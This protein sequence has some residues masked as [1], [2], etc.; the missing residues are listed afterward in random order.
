MRLAPAF[1]FLLTSARVLAAD[2]ALV[3]G[4][5]LPAPDAPPVTDAVI[6][7]RD[8]RIAAI[9]PRASVVVPPAAEVLDCTGKFLTAGFWNVHVHLIGPELAGAGQAPAAQLEAALTEM[10]TRWGFTTAFDLASGLD[11]TLALRERIAR[12][13]VAGP[14]ILT[15]GEPLWPEMP[16]YVR[17]S[18]AARTFPFPPVTTPEA[19]AERV[20]A[21]AARGV[22]GIKLFTGSM[23]PRGA[24]TNMPAEVARAA[25]TEADRLRLPVFSHPHNDPGTEA[26]IAAGVDILAH[27]AAMSP[28]WTPEFALRLKD[29]RVALVPTLALYR[30]EGRQIQLPPHVIEGWLNN[31]IGQVRAMHEAGGEILFGTDVGYIRQFD[32]TEDY[33]LLAKAGLDHRAILA[34]LTTAP[35]AR[36]GA[37]RRSGRLA[38]GF[39][40]D[41]V[42]LD[43]DPAQDVAALARVHATV[44]Q[45][46]FIYRSGQK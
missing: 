44:R 24:V 1:L 2:L 8:G 35:A 19:A 5:V 38:V 13:E 11:N 41:L 10:L 14:R 40:A 15:C 26:S 17:E 12:G 25:V 43:A 6:L 36:F 42:V 46:R 7:I 39:D 31:V 29:A 33:Q 28:A 20:R 22:D 23:Q 3:G 27:T 30:V 18:P 21:L 16:I 4:T 37:A 45:G 32:P 9:G 34:T